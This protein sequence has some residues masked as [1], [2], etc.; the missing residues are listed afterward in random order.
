[1][2][3]GH[4]ILTLQRQIVWRAWLTVLWLP[5]GATALALGREATNPPASIATGHA[6]GQ[7]PTPPHS[8][9]RFIL[10][11]LGLSVATLLSSVVGSS[12]LCAGASPGSLI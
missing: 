2:F 11:L 10:C 7:P 12:E 3:F 8:L 6:R 5:A 1:M 4:G 9:L